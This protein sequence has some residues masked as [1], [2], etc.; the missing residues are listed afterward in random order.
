M[1]VPSENTLDKGK[2]DKNKIL[3]QLSLNTPSPLN[4]REKNKMENNS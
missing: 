3:K 1:S 2:E 4:R